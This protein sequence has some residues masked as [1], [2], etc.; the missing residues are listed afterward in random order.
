MLGVESGSCSAVQVLLS[1]GSEVNAVD[2]RGETALEIVENKLEM[3]KMGVMNSAMESPV[4]VGLLGTG[5]GAG[6]DDTLRNSRISESVRFSID[7]IDSSSAILLDDNVQEMIT[8]ASQLR[9]QG[10][11]ATEKSIDAE[12]WKSYYI[13]C[14]SLLLANGAVKRAIKSVPVEQ[15][16]RDITFSYKKNGTYH[17][18]TATPWA[19]VNRLTT[20]PYFTSLHASNLLATYRLYLSPM[21]LLKLLQ[22]RYY[23][24]HGMHQQAVA[25]TVEDCEVFASL[26]VFFIEEEQV[27]YRLKMLEQVTRRAD[28]VGEGGGSNRPVSIK[29]AAASAP[30]SSNGVGKP[31][32]E[33]PMQFVMGIDSHVIRDYSGSRDDE[34]ALPGTK[35]NDQIIFRNVYV[36]KIS[37]FSPDSLVE[38]LM[39]AVNVCCNG[40]EL[41]RDCMLLL[42]RKRYVKIGCIQV[43][44]ETVNDNTWTL[45]IFNA[46]HQSGRDN[47]ASV[48]A[49]LTDGGE[50]ATEVVYPAMPEEAFSLSSLEVSCKPG[51][52][53][54]RG[55]VVVELRAQFINEIGK[56]SALT[57][58]AYLSDHYQNEMCE[59]FAAVLSVFVQGQD[60]VKL[61]PVEERFKLIASHPSAK[62]HSHNDIEYYNP[63]GQTVSSSN[64]KQSGLAQKG[65]ISRS[66]SFEE[67]QTL[68]SFESEMKHHAS[69]PSVF[70]GM[71]TV[72]RKASTESLIPSTTTSPSHSKRGFAS[73]RQSEASE[74]NRSSG[75][76][77]G[78]SSVASS[79][80]RAS[81]SERDGSLA[82]VTIRN[83]ANVAS[84]RGCVQLLSTWCT[85]FYEDDFERDAV[86]KVAMGRFIEEV[87]EHSGELIE[88]EF[89]PNVFTPFITFVADESRV[90]ELNDA[91]ACEDSVTSVT[92]ATSTLTI[93]SIRKSVVV[94]RTSLACG[95]EEQR[96][97][98]FSKRMSKKSFAPLKKRGTSLFDVFTPISEGIDDLQSFDETIKGQEGTVDA[99]L[100]YNLL[101]LRPEDVAEQLTLMEHT[102]FCRIKRSELIDSKQVQYNHLKELQAFTVHAMDWMISAVVSSRN[103]D[104]ASRKIAFLLRVSSHMQKIRNYN[105]MFEVL[106]ALETTSVYRL[107][108]AWSKLDAEANAQHAT[109]KALFSSRAGFQAF[110]KFIVGENCQPPCMPYLG[111]YLKD[112]IYILQLPSYVSPGIVNVT[113]MGSLACKVME[114]HSY[115]TTPYHFLSQPQMIQVLKSPP[116]FIT[117]DAQYQASIDLEPILTNRASSVS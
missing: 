40:V 96:A 95:G 52:R 42:I 36:G 46:K 5:G 114:I 101:E 80:M 74:S 70:H 90:L 94:S 71:R 49:A 78:T 2:H 8:F 111:L 64:F 48:D 61:V 106:T 116:Q 75:S 86:L 76:A 62:S 103:C 83:E 38:R 27:V 59:T 31:S 33:G 9:L 66:A 68:H 79:P 65:V 45:N 56:P 20:F 23:A 99:P 117:E 72:E 113:K 100:V 16:C 17:V 57:S 73:A 21:C 7:T 41:F 82:S 14:Q 107:K 108:S 24:L 105:G 28:N 53:L 12:K 51:H 104:E 39:H 85:D 97:S 50:A 88:E 81:V 98:V 4:K 77:H 22:L 92:D 19:L 43:H 11:R 13:E 93:S 63:N 1:Q 102:L 89:D 54:M 37:S 26:G 55:K 35:P 69:L 32:S 91:T 67:R 3:L 47:S 30:G 15:D 6:D 44:R 58:M 34:A 60:R 10:L 84:L 18:A 109:L 110:R 25:L 112:I 29:I 115:Q 87:M